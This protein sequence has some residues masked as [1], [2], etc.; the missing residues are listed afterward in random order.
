MNNKNKLYRKY[1]SNH[2]WLKYKKNINQ[3]YIN[4]ICKKYNIKGTLINKPYI[5]YNTNEFIY[6][7]IKINKY[8]KQFNKYKELLKYNNYDI[9]I[10]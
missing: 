2:W 4:K 3:Y 8:K 5:D 1:I 7:I 10:E 6:G 9:I